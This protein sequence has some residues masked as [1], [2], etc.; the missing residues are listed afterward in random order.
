MKKIILLLVFSIL[1][2]V[3]LSNNEE[4]FK[5]GNEFYRQG[6]Y[7]E[8]IN[9]YKLILDNGKHSFELYFNLGNSYYKINDITSAKLY[10]EKAKKIS[11]YDEEL[12]KNLN[13]TNS[14]LIDKIDKL[15]DPITTKIINYFFEIFNYKIWGYISLIFAF[16]I[17]PFFVLYKKS[18]SIESQ[19]IYLSIFIISLFICFLSLFASLKESKKLNE[20][21]A[22][23]YSHNS[24]IKSEPKDSSEDLFILHEGTLLLI[25]EKS[26]GWAKI[27]LEDGKM[28][29]IKQNDISEI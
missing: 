27:K 16:I 23:V 24:Y 17:F 14:L 4:I 26:E 20:I 10:Y 28:G 18:K 8:A 19:K 15:E 9:S 11:P 22:I 25:L 7:Q 2:N 3:L 1:S 12:L 13:I 29:W 5:Q 21:K 6:N